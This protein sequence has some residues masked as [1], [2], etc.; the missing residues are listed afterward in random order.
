MLV[1]S[2]AHCDSS[3]FRPR[4][5][6]CTSVPGCMVQPLDYRVYKTRIRWIIMD[7]NCEQEIS[8]GYIIFCEPPPVVDC[9]AIIFSRQ[10]YVTVLLSVYVGKLISHDA[11]TCSQLRDPQ[12]RAHFRANALE[13]LVRVQM[14]KI[15]SANKVQLRHRTCRSGGNN[16]A[17]TSKMQRSP[18]FTIEPPCR[19]A[20]RL[21][22]L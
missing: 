3:A 4:M 7:N 13:T 18:S 22:A 2:V 10:P 15:R 17:Y 11:V 8:Q 21:S 6:G 19:S 20:Q 16:T 14:R 1:Y 5:F 12:K 9:T